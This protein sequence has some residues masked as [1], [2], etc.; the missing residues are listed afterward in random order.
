MG[1]KRRGPTP[2]WGFRMVAW[3]AILC[4]RFV[5][6]RVTTEG[7]HHVP[8][9]GGAVVV[10]NHTGHVDFVTVAFEVFRRLHRQIRFLAKRELWASR[11]TRLIVVVVGAVPVDRGAGS[12]RARSFSAAVA[13]LRAGDLVGVAPEGTIS[14]TFELLPFRSGAA[15]MAQDAQVPVVPCVSWGS[16]RLSTSGYG[17]S[18]RR[19]YRIP[20]VVRFGEP[21]HVAP[22]EDVHLATARIRAATKGLLHEVQEGYPGGTPAGAW[23][24]PAR[25]GGGAPTRT[26]PAHDAPVTEPGPT[27]DPP[28]DRSD[29]R[30][31]VQDDHRSA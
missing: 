7:L 14:E 12:G 4:V 22:G 1:R 15:R 6:W 23:W 3:L 18:P 31:D 20:V 28:F 13:G 10:W 8:R 27:T 9:A 26:G 25:L 30:L 19:S 11:W 29:G 16:H 21:I 5:R 24:V 2:S 17:F